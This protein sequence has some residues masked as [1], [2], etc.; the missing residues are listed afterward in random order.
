MTTSSR[1]AASLLSSLYLKDMNM[2]DFEEGVDEDPRDSS[3]MVEN[4]EE[5]ENEVL[6]DDIEMSETCVEDKFNPI[7]EPI[8]EY[9]FDKQ[10]ENYVRKHYPNSPD[11]Y[12]PEQDY[13]REELFTPTIYH[14]LPVKGIVKELEG[15]ANLK[16]RFQRSYV[17]VNH[18]EFHTDATLE[19]VFLARKAF[20]YIYNMEGGEDLENT[21]DDEPEWTRFL[22]DKV[23]RHYENFVLYM[24]K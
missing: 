11:T 20:A 4:S 19:H 5:V 3:Y 6:K 17:I 7:T 24:L 12:V 21:V 2:N 14:P 9:F 10:M 13:T 15:L 22:L 16:F 1:P 8:T 23:V 18:P